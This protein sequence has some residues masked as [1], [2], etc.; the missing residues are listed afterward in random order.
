MD[1]VEIFDSP[2]NLFSHII[3]FFTSV[4]YPKFTVFK[5]AVI[6]FLSFLS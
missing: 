3:I 4:S 2:F 6:L 5:S 1:V